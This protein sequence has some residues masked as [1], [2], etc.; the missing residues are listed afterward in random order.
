MAKRKKV[1]KVLTI[2]QV[3][4]ICNASPRTV[5]KWFDSGLL[6]GYRLPGSG[7]R[8]IPVA[9]LIRFMKAHN[10]PMTELRHIQE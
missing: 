6:N 5:A 4:R 3:A 8:R 9:E 7:D 10:M 1:L 2:G